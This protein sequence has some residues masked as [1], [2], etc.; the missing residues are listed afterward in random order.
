MPTCDTA[1]LVIPIVTAAARV[2]RYIARLPFVRV[3]AAQN[4]DGNPGS[5]ALRL[6]FL[7]YNPGSIP[8]LRMTAAASGAVIYFSSACAASTGPA[9]V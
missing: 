5:A 4:R 3:A 1:W 8:V 2:N 9:A 6:C 7:F